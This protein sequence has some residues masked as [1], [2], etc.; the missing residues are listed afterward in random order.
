[1]TLL[2]IDTMYLFPYVFPK[3]NQMLCN[4]KVFF[5][6]EIVKGLHFVTSML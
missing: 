5:K 6:H 4:N 1:L 3:K 2:L